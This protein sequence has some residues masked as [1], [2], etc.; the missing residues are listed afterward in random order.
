[1]QPAD[2]PVPAAALRLS[3]SATVRLTNDP[4]FDEP[5]ADSIAS[6]RRTLTDIAV[7]IADA[8][9]RKAL[10]HGALPSAND[11]DVLRRAVEG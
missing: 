6:A 7:R 1:M 11:V 8:R 9:A 4:L 10:G 3:V 5:K 2:S